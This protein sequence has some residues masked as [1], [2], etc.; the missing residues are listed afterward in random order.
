MRETSRNRKQRQSNGSC[1]SGLVALNKWASEIGITP[2]TAWRFRKRG[3]I[4]TVNI[5]GRVYL[6][7]EG[8]ANF[9][10]RAVA[11]EFAKEHKAPGR[12]LAQIA[13]AE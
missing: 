7:P 2:I 10:R 9:N 8:I 1:A 4:E 13:R 12:R 3:W 11:G 6:T 5:C